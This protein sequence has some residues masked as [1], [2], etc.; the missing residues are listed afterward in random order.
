MNYSTLINKDVISIYDGQTIGK[1]LFGIFGKQKLLK[2]VIQHNDSN[3]ILDVKNIF[4]FKFDNIM[5]KN[6]TNLVI[7]QSENQNHF[8]QKNVV[9]VL[10]QNLGNIVDIIFDEK[11][12]ITKIITNKTE[13]CLRDIVTNKEKIII[14]DKNGSY[15]NFQFA[16]KKKIEI[17]KN[18]NQKVQITTKIP[19]K[20]TSGSFLIGKKLFRD[21]KTPSNITL[22]RKNQIVTLSLVNLAKDHGCL[23]TLINSVL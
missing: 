19:I 8:L 3:I 11:F 13:F 7:A 21:I 22:A 1:T 23:N 6:N 15:K 2:L 9:S 16:P 4:S 20:V 5:I 10:G 12:F 17:A 18:L 14:N